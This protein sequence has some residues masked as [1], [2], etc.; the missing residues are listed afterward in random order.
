MVGVLQIV[1][2]NIPLLV[3]M[4]MSVVRAV[5]ILPAAEVNRRINSTLDSVRGKFYEQVAKAVDTNA[6]KGV[7]CTRVEVPDT[8]D[9]EDFD[10]LTREGYVCKFAPGYHIGEDRDWIPGTLEVCVPR[11]S[12]ATPAAAAP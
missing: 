5:G 10:V 12:A 7:R 6:Q 2:I 3:L 11:R 8:L 1:F 9:A 4:S